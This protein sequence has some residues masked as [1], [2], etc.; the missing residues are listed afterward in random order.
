M[1]F[2][3]IGQTLRMCLVTQ[4]QENSPET[5][6]TRVA[7]LR[8]DLAAIELP[9]SE[10]TGRSRLFQPGTEWDVWY[11]AD[12]GSRYDFRTEVVGK[13]NDNIPVLLIKLPS[14]D[15]LK[16]TQRR[17]YLRMN[18]SVEIA[19]KTEHPVRQYHFLARTVDL[20]GGGLSFTCPD[21]YRLQVHDRLHVWMSLPSRSGQVA[22]AQAVVEIM[23]TTPP[24]EKGQHQWISGKFV[25]IN[26]RDQSKIVRACYERQL[27]LRKKS[28]SE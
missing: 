11:I 6:K 28:F 22:H 8:Q 23:R 2:P 13:S 21:S 27:E 3:R 19:V 18:A 9:I 10:T 4:S 12:D 24:R 17:N 26:E 15:S 14:K 20:S 7:D 25:Q 5:Y 1:M 16:R